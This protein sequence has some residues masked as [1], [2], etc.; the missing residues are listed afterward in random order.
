MVSKVFVYIFGRGNIY[1]LGLTL[2]IFI[3]VAII[4]ILS[5]K[6]YATERLRTKLGCILQKATLVLSGVFIIIVLKLIS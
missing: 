6:C 5:H 2:G 3:Q 1:I 4:I